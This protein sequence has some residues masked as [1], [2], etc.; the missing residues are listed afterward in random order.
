[1]IISLNMWTV[2]SQPVTNIGSQQVSPENKA[3]C[4]LQGEKTNGEPIL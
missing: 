4:Q 3:G 2:L 1:M